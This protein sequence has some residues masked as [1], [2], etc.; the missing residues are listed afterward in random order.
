MNEH[1]LLTSPSELQLLRQLAHKVG[2][3]PLLTQGST[4]NSSLKQDGVLWIKKSGT[5]MADAL[6]D[7]IHVPLDLV[8]LRHCL[9]QGIE[10]RERY[11]RSSVETAMHAVLPH[12]VVLHVHCVSTIAWAVRSD[13]PI[14]LQRRLEGLPWHW[15]HY[16]ASGLPLSR[17]VE[18]ALRVRPGQN[19][20]VLGNHGLVVAG[21]DVETVQDLLAEVNKRLVVIPR[22]SPAANYAALRELSR[23][24]RWTLP[25]EDNMHS[26][27]TDAI[28]QNI[29]A[30]GL[31]HP[32]QADIASC[33]MSGS[34]CSVL[35]DKLSKQ[36]RNRFADPPFL[37]VKGSGVV[38]SRCIKPAQLA[39][40]SG[41][42]QVVQRL[43]ES[44]PLHYLNESESAHV[45]NHGASR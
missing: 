38:V 14:Q 20:F 33:W 41:L 16:Q 12:R 22:Q 30:R 36:R 26:I 28:S 15:I 2:S 1:R 45:I 44:T 3:D 21:E 43:G 19:V 32:C 6:R 17:A 18:H 35:V 13:A 24:T 40:I 9:Q 10:P 23:G 31:L 42:V 29:L 7:E 37:I 27:G 25:N 8:T 34:S 39:L 4:G 11:P 5:W